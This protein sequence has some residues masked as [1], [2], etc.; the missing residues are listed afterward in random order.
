MF[1][2][3]EKTEILGETADSKLSVAQARQ[4][5][6]LSLSQK[7]QRGDGAPLPPTCW[8]VL[9][10]KLQPQLPA[11]QGLCKKCFPGPPKL[12]KQFTIKNK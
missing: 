11:H 4:M 3:S 8:S 5:V 12:L 9:R 6:W 10:Y 7:G 2:V 1:E